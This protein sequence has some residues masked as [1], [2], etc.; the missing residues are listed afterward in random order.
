MGEPGFDG[1]GVADGE[2]DEV[3]VDQRGEAHDVVHA[4]LVG[5]H[6][7]RRRVQ[8]AQLVLHGV[9]HGAQLPQSRGRVEVSMVQIESQRGPTRQQQRPSKARLGNRR[10][11]SPHDEGQLEGVRVEGEVVERV[12]DRF[13][14]SWPRPE[15]THAQ[16]S[17]YKDIGT[18]RV[19]CWS[20]S[21]DMPREIRR[22]LQR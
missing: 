1:E 7:V 20:A 4:I 11:S 12:Q 3:T 6:Q 2:E 16:S 14:L 5:R 18:A 9:P 15:R 13:E 21:I 17:S 22:N 10:E 19:R 8:R